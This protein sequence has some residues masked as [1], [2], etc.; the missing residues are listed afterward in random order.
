MEE[1]GE[2]WG[3][4][5]YDLVLR[6]LTPYRWDFA[7]PELFTFLPL[8]TQSQVFGGGTMR[9]MLGIQKATTSP[10]PGTNQPFTQTR[11]SE[12]R[13]SFSLCKFVISGAG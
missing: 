4:S 11:E 5:L 10:R 2:L 8:V 6:L 13:Q 1:Y 9:W 12:P 7:S 3:I